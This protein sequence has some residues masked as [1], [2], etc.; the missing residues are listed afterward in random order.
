MTELYQPHT[1]KPLDS[2]GNRIRRLH[3]SLRSMTD[4]EMQKHD[5]TAEQWHPLLSI[6]FGKVKTAS[7]LAQEIGMDTGATTRMLDRLQKKGLLIRNPCIHDRRVMQ[8]TLTDTGLRV[9]EKIPTDL[10]N[11]MNRHLKGFNETEL[12]TLKSLLA[13]M[14]ANG[15]HQ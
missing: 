14:L 1:Y 4:S 10:C 9:C 15:E 5:L 8:L 7:A 3:A 6:Y 11:V 12:S 13:R 2:V